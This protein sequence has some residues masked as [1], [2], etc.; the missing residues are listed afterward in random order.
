MRRPT[1]RFALIAIAWLMT[2]GADPTAMPGIKGTDDRQLIR[3]TD[4]PWRAI[5]RLNKRTGG[6]CTGTLIAPDMVLTAAHCLWHKRTLSWVPT[7]TL[8][9]V[10]GYQLG[11]WVA[12]SKVVA[13]RVA[14]SYRFKQK[15]K[16]ADQAF[17][18]AVVTLA[19]PIGAQVGTIPPAADGRAAVADASAKRRPVTQAGYSRDKKHILTVHEGCHLGRYRKSSGLVDHDCD[20]VSGDSGSPILS[21]RDNKPTVIA[22]HVATA[23]AGK[24]GIRRGLAV[25]L[26]ARAEW[27]ARI[28][29]RP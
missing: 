18:W 5:G 1:L 2:G 7:E 21:F 28:V 15:P 11:E 16:L 14:R 9:F 22:I 27:D 17:D 23:G 10:A 12:A 19:E 6:H 24:S 20:T 8:H 25:A 13:Y 26:P 29:R 4:Y 3:T